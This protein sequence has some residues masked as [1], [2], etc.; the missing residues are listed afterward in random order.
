[1]PHFSYGFITPT[2]TALTTRWI[3]GALC[4]AFIAPFLSYADIEL[5]SLKQPV[6]V[7]V[8]TPLSTAASTLQTPVAVTVPDAIHWKNSTI[9]AGTTLQGVLTENTVARR[10]GRPARM[11]VGVTSIT[12]P[13]QQPTQLTKPL[14]VTLGTNPYES[15]RSLVGR[16]VVIS[17][18]AR[19]ATIPLYLTTG[20][21]TMAIIGIGSG[22]S[23][24]AGTGQELQKDD[25]YDDRSTGHKA[26]VGAFR[27]ATGI[28]T[29][30]GLAKKGDNL[31]YQADELV[32][33]SLEEP[34]WN[35]LLQ[36][37]PINCP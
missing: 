10:W 20:L 35:V 32:M 15:G 27:G 12:L 3:L 33:V 25:T 16:Q 26:A 34:L 22:I 6:P 30:V 24:V 17:G 18:I 11:T 23:A 21:G 2:K 9:P 8:Q 1:M 4:C 36:P 14:E 31:N 13:G 29:L 28:P 7:M 5:G 37:C 19:A